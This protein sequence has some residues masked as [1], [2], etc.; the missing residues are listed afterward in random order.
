MAVDYRGMEEFEMLNALGDDASKWAEA[1]MQFKE[2]W[3]KRGQKIDFD[4]M[5]TWFSC[6]IE[7]GHDVRTRADL[8]S[9]GLGSPDPKYL[10]PTLLPANPQE[11]T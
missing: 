8:E 4:L 7:T 5:I 1:F 2:G 6:A 10:G 9:M 11:G 3:D